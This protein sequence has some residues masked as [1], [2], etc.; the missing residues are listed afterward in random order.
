[1]RTISTTQ[2]AAK[3]GYSDDTI[4]R[5]CEAGRIPAVR[6]GR[7]WKVSAEWVERALLKLRGGST[8]VTR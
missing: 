1:M 8:T 5:Q 2:A 6:V 4:R 3:L 7:T